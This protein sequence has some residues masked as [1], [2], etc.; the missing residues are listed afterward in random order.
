MP[1]ILFWSACLE[2]TTG[3][4]DCECIFWERKIKFF[5][6]DEFW[7]SEDFVPN[8]LH[9]QGCT[10]TATGRPTVGVSTE[11]SWVL[12]KYKDYFNYLP[13]LVYTYVSVIVGI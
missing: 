3:Q 7:S 9:K 10:K 12:M 4:F 6:W 8:G 11:G 5:T 1:R 2:C 13:P